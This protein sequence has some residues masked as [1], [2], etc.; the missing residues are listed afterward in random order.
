MALT[1]AA[2]VGHAG[3]SAASGNDDN[4]PPTTTPSTTAAPTTT[5]PAPPTPAPPTTMTVPANPKTKIPRDCMA[6]EIAR[7]GAKKE[8]IFCRVARGDGK[9]AI[10]AKVAEK[11]AR[12]GAKLEVVCPVPKAARAIVEVPQN[13]G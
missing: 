3:I 9:C 5:Q 6:D 2:A 13:T 10:E 4:P 12:S 8:V 11:V 1:V 7:S